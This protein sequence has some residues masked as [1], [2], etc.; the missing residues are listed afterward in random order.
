MKALGVL[1]GAIKT[2]HF[3]AL[4]QWDSLVPGKR[5]GQAGDACATPPPNNDIQVALHLDLIIVELVRT[6]Q[7]S[8]VF[9]TKQL[10]S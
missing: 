10:L 6:Y 3:H 1:T 2:Q 7:S 9:I 4:R 5:F 8:C